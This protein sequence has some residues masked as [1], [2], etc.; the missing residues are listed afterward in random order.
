MKHLHVATLALAALL[1]IGAQAALKPGDAA[2]E[3]KTTAAL[4]IGRSGAAWWILGLFAN[5]LW[6]FVDRDRQF[7]HDRLAGTRVVF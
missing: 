3:F 1:P 5:F 6:A 7:L 4:A 2:P